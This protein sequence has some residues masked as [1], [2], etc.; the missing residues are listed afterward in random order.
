MYWAHLPITMYTQHVYIVC[1]RAF[2]L[3]HLFF[4]HH[5]LLHAPGAGMWCDGS[6]EVD[7]WGRRV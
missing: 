3:P 5:I 1:V 7:F 6:L 4:H 2:A